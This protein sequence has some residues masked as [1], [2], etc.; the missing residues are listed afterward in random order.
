MMIRKAITA[1]LNN[2]FRSTSLNK[3]GMSLRYYGKFFKKK[4]IKSFITK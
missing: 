3:N 4:I 1:T 2:V